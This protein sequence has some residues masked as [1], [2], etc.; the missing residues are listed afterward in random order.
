MG[1]GDAKLGLVI[2]LILGASSGFSAV[3]FAF[4]LG[5]A[6]GIISMIF[7]HKKIT[8]KSEVPFAPFLVLGAWLALIF[9][10]DLLH[11]S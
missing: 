3:I 1:F 8:M 9:N 6:F 2:G 10:L 7:S 11:V 4:W 5:A